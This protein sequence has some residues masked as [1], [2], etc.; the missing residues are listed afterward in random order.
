MI[1]RDKG[2]PDG[3]ML[4]LV[5]KLLKRDTTTKG[6]KVKGVDGVQP[7]TYAE[8]V[9]FVEE[10]TQLV[11]EGTYAEIHMCETCK[12]FSS[13]KGS[14]GVCF[15]DTFTSSR[16]R[17]DYCSGWEHMT[18]DQARLRRKISELQA[19]RVGD[20]AEGSVESN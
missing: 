13:S 17:T 20:D 9:R 7:I 16:L 11:R 4:S 8:V 2:I 18:E 15:P 14:R 3:T 5:S 19:K 6:F 1:L 10:L 12:H